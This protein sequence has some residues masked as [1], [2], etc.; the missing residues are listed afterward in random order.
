M[1]CPMMVRFKTVSDPE[2]PEGLVLS[3]ETVGDLVPSIDPPMVV[4]KS[5]FDLDSAFLAAGIYLRDISHPDPERSALPKP[6]Q[7]YEVTKDILRKIGFD[8]PK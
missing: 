5:K 1:V 3:F 4:F 7:D 6:E 2:N 8:L